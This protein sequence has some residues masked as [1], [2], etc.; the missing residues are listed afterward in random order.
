[1]VL[2]QNGLEKKNWMLWLKKLGIL[3]LDFGFFGSEPF[4]KSST[5]AKKQIQAKQKESTPRIMSK[6]TK[7]TE[8]I[9]RYPFGDPYNRSKVL[10][11]L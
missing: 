2:K 3:W 10:L 9:G 8:I 7:N 5:G 4:L 11:T 6:D 1:M